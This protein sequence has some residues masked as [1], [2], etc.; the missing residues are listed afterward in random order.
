MRFSFRQMKGASPDLPSLP[1]RRNS[2]LAAASHVLPARGILCGLMASTGTT[3]SPKD[4]QPLETQA[5]SQIQ[6]CQKLVH[7]I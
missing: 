2:A 1:A 5:G 3:S 6:P 4:S 7:V